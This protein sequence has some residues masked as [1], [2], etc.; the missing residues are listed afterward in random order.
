MKEKWG[1]GISDTAMTSEFISR[2]KEYARYIFTDWADG[3]IGEQASAP[4]T[5]T[6]FIFS[7]LREM[8]IMTACGAFAAFMFRIYNGFAVRL[9]ETRRGKLLQ[10]AADILF[11]IFTGITVMQFWF[12]S[13]YGRLSVHEFIGLAAGFAVGMRA[14]AF[15]K[16]KLGHTIA[17]IYVI[18][19]ITAYFIIL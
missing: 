10:A 15:G 4:L 16:S 11:C 18:L 17:T 5:G 3:F 13:S 6:D 1:T 2:I 9:G 19:I 14:F 12:R 7:Q 8:M